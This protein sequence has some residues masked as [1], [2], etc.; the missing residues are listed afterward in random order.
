MANKAPAFQFYPKEY[1]SDKKVVRLN[2]EE[3]GVYHT[4]LCHMW[5]DSDDQCSIENDEELLREILHL[6]KKKFGKIFKKI[7]R[8]GSEIFEICQNRLVSKRLKE[9]K[10]KQM[11]LSIKRQDAAN[12]RWGKKESKSNASALQKECSAFASST[13]T[14]SSLKE[15]NT[16]PIP[17]GGDSEGYSPE[18]EALWEIYPR[19]LEKIKAYKAYKARIKETKHEILLQ[20]VRHYAELCRKAGKEQ[21]HIKQPKTF[22]GPDKVWQDFVNGIPEGE[23]PQTNPRPANNG[24]TPGQ[25]EPEYIPPEPKSQ[26]AFEIW[27]A[28]KK[29]LKKKIDCFNDA[30]DAF[31]TWFLLTWGYDLDGEKLLVAVPSPLFT[32]WL[33]DHYRGFIGEALG[34]QEFEFVV[35]RG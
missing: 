27:E 6:P 5:N 2:Y 29:K 35:V 23:L 15:K 20:A 14:A 22:L 26:E 11:E 8:P 3:K 4:L 18:F 32:A 34:G 9:E 16:P 21:R 7:Q 28:A 13:P 30:R 31:D 10:E 1:L 17:L 19:K 25:P 12:K 33:M 24:T